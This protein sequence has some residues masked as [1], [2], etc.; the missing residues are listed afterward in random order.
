MSKKPVIAVIGTGIM[1]TGIARNFLENGYTVHTWNRSPER[2][3]DLVRSGAELASTPRKAAANADI[4]FEV[5]ANDDSSRS[6]WLGDEGI[7]VGAGPSNVMITCATLSVDWTD[8]LAK[9]CTEKNQPFF[10]MPMT[11][12]RKGAENGNLILLS[13]GD[14]T[15]LS[16]LKPDLK[17]IAKDI[18]Y[19]GSAGS[20]MRYKLILNSLQAVL[21][22]E[23]GEA[24]R[25]SRETGLDDE[26]VAKALSE[27]PGGYT[28]QLMQQNYPKSPRPIN[29]SVDWITKDL[30]YA[31]QMATGS[32]YPLLE[33]ALKEYEKKVLEGGG[34]DDW[35]SISYPE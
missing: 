28:L 35:S 6:V 14:K 13:G 12:G 23:F 20:G 5:T 19:F 22:A 33:Q 27:L 18:L 10:D 32:A 9:I 2:M 30:K 21:I 34:Q 7:L 24:M 16:S 17:A 1:G 3:K 11:G 26:V 31:K 25:M 29:F 8:E 4:V 15:K